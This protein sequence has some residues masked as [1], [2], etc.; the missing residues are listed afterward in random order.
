MLFD[1]KWDAYCH[2]LK[3]KRNFVGAINVKHVMDDDKFWA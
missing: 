3:G 2:S 1:A